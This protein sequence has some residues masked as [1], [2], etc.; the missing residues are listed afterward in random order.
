M[1]ERCRGSN[2]GNRSFIKSF[3]PGANF[4]LW[5]IAQLPVLLNSEADD[6]SSL[7][8]LLRFR[9]HFGVPIP[10][11]YPHQISR[12]TRE[13]HAFVRGYYLQ[14]VRLMVGFGG[15]GTGILREHD[16]RSYSER[17]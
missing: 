8:I 7:Y 6:N 12:K 13:V 5:H 10:F 4:N 1:L 15:F 14:K 9:R 3:V 11:D 2:G 17:H 16:D